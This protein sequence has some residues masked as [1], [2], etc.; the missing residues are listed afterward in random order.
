[1]NT[2]KP[3]FRPALRGGFSRDLGAPFR[4]QRISPCSSALLPER[5]RGWVLTVIQSKIFLFLARGDSHHL[6]GVTDDVGGRFWPL[7]P[8]GI[9]L[10]SDARGKLIEWYRSGKQLELTLVF[11]SPRQ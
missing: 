3:S 1:M 7:G 2:V 5:L 6:D 11:S 9:D 4:R 8:V 10:L